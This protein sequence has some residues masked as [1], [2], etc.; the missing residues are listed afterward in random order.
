MWRV[1]EAVRRTPAQVL[2]R[3]SLQHNVVAV[4]CT[5]SAAHLAENAPSN[6]AS[7]A[8][9]AGAMRV[10]N[11]LHRLADVSAWRRPDGFDPAALLRTIE[12]AR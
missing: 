3:W 8:L 5:A 7:F 1:A 2:L 11:E 6:I 4:P 12:Q 10:L 9:G